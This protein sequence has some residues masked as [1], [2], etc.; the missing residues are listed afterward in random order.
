MVQDKAPVWVV[1]VL[2]KMVDAIRVEERGPPL[3]A[4]D[5]IALVQQ[6]LCQVSAV[7]AGDTG[8]QCLLHARPS[9]SEKKTTGAE[10]NNEQN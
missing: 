10:T 5:L 8:D 6:Q 1:W 2:I 9:S 7:L 3:D 4:V